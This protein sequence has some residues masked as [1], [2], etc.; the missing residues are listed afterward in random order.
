MLF[1]DLKTYIDVTKT[2]KTDFAR[3]VGVSYDQ[4]AQ[5][6]LGT[7]PIPIRYCAAIEKLTSAHVTRKEMR[8]DDWAAIWPELAQPK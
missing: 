4:F 7:R 8:P 2:R 1:M 6:L 3:S 5:W